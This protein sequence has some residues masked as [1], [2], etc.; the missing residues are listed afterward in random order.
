[1]REESGTVL[2]IEKDGRMNVGDKKKDV[3]ILGMKGSHAEA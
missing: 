3:L 1:M 2:H